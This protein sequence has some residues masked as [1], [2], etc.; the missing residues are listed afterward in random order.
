MPSNRP[1]LSLIHRYCA[2]ISERLTGCR[3]WNCRGEADGQQAQPRS[4]CPSVSWGWTAGAVF[5]V[6]RVW[7][8][9]SAAGAAPRLR[10]HASLPPSLTPAHPGGGRAPSVM[11]VQGDSRLRRAR[12]SRAAGAGLW[13]RVGGGSGR[14][15]DARGGGPRTPAARKAP[16]WSGLG[17]HDPG[18]TQPSERGLPR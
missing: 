7:L 9:A 11:W 8:E 3:D 6:K 16:A 1:S 2:C 15:A 12:L 14:R 13:D 10:A 5:W 4:P 17:P 18:N